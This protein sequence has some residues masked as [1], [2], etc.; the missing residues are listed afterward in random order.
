MEKEREW[1]KTF[2]ERSEGLNRHAAEEHIGICTLAVFY[3]NEI[4]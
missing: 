2:V 1:K 3:R 4:V